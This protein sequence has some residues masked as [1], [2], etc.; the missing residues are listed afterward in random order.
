MDYRRRITS[1]WKRTRLSIRN[2]CIL[3][4]HGRIKPKPEIAELHGKEVRFVDGSREEIDNVVF[5]RQDFE[6]RFRLWTRLILN[7]KEG[8]P[9]LFLNA[10]HPRYNNFFIAGLIQ[11]DSGI[12][13][14]VHYQ[15]QLIARFLKAQR[16]S[17]GWRNGSGG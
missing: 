3:S 4:G 14:L 11:P 8:K 6:F 1:F 16:N 5:M 12:W 9:E 2:C 10:F 17:H 13:G 15:A 7:W